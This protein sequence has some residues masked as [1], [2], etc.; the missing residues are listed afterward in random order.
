MDNN[1][2]ITKLHLNAAVPSYYLE[3]ELGELV[4]DIVER[5]SKEEI[6]QDQFIDHMQGFGFTA[7]EIMD[8]Y[9]DDVLPWVL[10]KLA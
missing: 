8:I 3:G 7:Q 2:M 6:D 5:A 10:G 9:C 4:L 1:D